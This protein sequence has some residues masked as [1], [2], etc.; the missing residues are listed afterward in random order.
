M[1]NQVV[2]EID[3]L[4]PEGD[5]WSPEELERLGMNLYKAAAM[6]AQA[7]NRGVAARDI[8]YLRVDVDCP[9]YNPIRDL[10]SNEAPADMPIFLE[11]EPFEGVMSAILVANMFSAFTGRPAESFIASD[12]LVA[13]VRMT[14]QG[15]FR[16]NARLV[17]MKTSGERPS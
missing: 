3:L 17:V 13:L 10:C 12:G 6:L 1:S 5:T 7:I 4:P 8:L 11:N 9:L 16:Q 14:K 2:G 15:I